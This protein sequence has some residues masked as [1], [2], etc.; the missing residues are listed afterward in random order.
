MMPTWSIELVP[1]QP[2]LCKE[3][4]HQEKQQQQQQQQQQRKGKTKPL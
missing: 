2:G 4:L 3:I 1:G